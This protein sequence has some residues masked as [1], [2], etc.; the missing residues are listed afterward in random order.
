M[1]HLVTKTLPRKVGR[2]KGS[3]NKKKATPK[4]KPT[5]RKKAEPEDLSRVKISKFLGYCPRGH[6]IAL[7]DKR[8]PRTFFCTTCGKKYSTSK[9]KTERSSKK[10]VPINKRKYLK[11][12]RESGEI[13]NNK[14]E[15]VLNE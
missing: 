4:K 11:E 5:K 9:I 2:P 10:T 3:K 7:R 13:K 14:V 8:T 1:G 15:E 6:M 12:L